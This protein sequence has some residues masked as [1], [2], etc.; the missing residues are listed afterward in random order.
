MLASTLK[1]SIGKLVRIN[2]IWSNLSA[3][4][5][6]INS[7]GAVFHK[8]EIIDYLGVA[9]VMFVINFKFFTKNYHKEIFFT[10]Y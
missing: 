2:S 10:K 7:V 5:V 9:I 4:M 1:L 3:K 8:K 6:I